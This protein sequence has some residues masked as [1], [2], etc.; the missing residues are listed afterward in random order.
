MTTGTP[1]PTAEIEARIAEAELNLAE[2][3]NELYR[4]KVRDALVSNALRR[5]RDAKR[6][7]L[8]RLESGEHVVAVNGGRHW[9]GDEAEPIRERASADEVD[10]LRELVAAGVVEKSQ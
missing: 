2:L 9:W 4:A 8:S 5:I 1:R 3:R 10:A 6:H 7:V